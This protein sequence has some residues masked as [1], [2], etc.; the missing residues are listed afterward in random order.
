MPFI[1]AFR[2][3]QFRVN[4]E[5][6]MT[7]LVSLVPE[8]A[9]TGDQKTKP[10]QNAVRELRGLGLSPDLIACRSI[11]A[12]SLEAREKVAHFCHVLPEQVCDITLLFA[13]FFLGIVLT[14]LSNYRISKN[15][16]LNTVK[17]L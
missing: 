14:N 9:C 4:R 11:R 1:E 15:C 16:N 10:T 12:L 3:F 7:I 13:V 6:F 2:S 17:Y 8:P 5:N